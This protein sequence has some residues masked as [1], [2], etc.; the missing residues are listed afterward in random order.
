ME[1]DP[2]K[3]II[4]ALTQQPMTRNQL[5]KH[6]KPILTESTTKNHIR[7]MVR[8][9]KLFESEGSKFGSKLGVKPFQTLQ[10][11]IIKLLKKKP[12]SAKAISVALNNSRTVISC[13][14]TVMQGKNIVQ[15]TG[16]AYKDRLW[17]IIQVHETD[18]PKI[19][20]ANTVKIY[21][22]ISTTLK[23]TPWQGLEAFL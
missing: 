5:A 21:N 13:R 4:D 23:G 19:S 9:K 6:L 7:A 2:K 12:M 14:L 18:S 8:Q 11:Q 22:L 10:D 15:C 20:Q 1:N 17:E 3:I 16:G